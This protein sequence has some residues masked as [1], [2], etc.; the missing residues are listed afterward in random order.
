MV[1]CHDHHNSIILILPIVR[2]SEVKVQVTVT[3]INDNRPI[4]TEDEYVEHV[5]EFI[6]VGASVIQVKKQFFLPL[7]WQY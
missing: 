5:V 1:N 2:S 4:F 3:D 6:P 7:N